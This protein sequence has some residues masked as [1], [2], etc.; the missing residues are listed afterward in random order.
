M[1]NSTRLLSK[2]LINITCIAHLGFLVTSL[3]SPKI[4]FSLKWDQ[5]YK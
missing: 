1:E 3:I 2:L 4:S 5:Y